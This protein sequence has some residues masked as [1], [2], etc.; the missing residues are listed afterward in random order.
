MDFVAE[1]YRLIGTLANLLL[2]PCMQPEMSNELKVFCLRI[3]S[4]APYGVIS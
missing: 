4:L 3:L 2:E 1:V